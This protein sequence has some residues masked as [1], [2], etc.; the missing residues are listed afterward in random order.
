MKGVSGYTIIEVMIFL[1]VSTAM[2]GSA[3][4]LITGRQRATAF[5]A[6]MRDIE[7]SLNDVLND[8]DTGFY[9]T[10]AKVNCSVSGASLA[11][12]DVGAGNADIGKN[13]QCVILGKVI[14]FGQTAAKNS[15]TSYVVAGRKT[16]IGAQNVPVIVDKFSESYPTVVSLDSTIDNYLFPNGIEL[17][18]S[19]TTPVS[20]V[21][22]IYSSQSGSSLASYEALGTDPTKPSSIKLKSGSQQ[23]RVDAYNLGFGAALGSIQSEISVPTNLKLAVFCFKGP[24]NNQFAKIAIGSLP[25]G[26]GTRL[27]FVSSC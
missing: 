27:D 18:S 15:Y 19:T 3:T 11:I 17:K 20:A 23:T 6:G 4:Y 5:S 26:Q 25:G 12:S 21:V 22:G 1:V 2:L 9:N 10:S 7:S 24:Y 14:A 8:V 16:K 13:G